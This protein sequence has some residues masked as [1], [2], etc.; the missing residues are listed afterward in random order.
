MEDAATGVA[1]EGAAT[2]VVVEG[3]AAG[4]TVEGAGTG[5]ATAEELLGVVEGRRSPQPNP[6]A[7][8]NNRSASVSPVGGA[9]SWR[10]EDGGLE[11]KRHSES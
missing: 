3:P 1:V 2:G 7:I 9:A 6:R 10:A 11:A 8:S 4:V 5:G